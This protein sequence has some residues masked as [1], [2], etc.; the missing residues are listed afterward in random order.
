[1]TVPVTDND[2]RSSAYRLS[3]AIVA[4]L[5]ADGVDPDIAGNPDQTD[6]DVFAESIDFDAELYMSMS[7]D[8][9]TEEYDEI[10]KAA[11]DTK[12]LSDPNGVVDA[13]KTQMD[14][15]WHGEAAQTFSGQ[16]NRIQLCISKQHEF[17]LLAA[18]SVS[19]MYA[20]SVQFRASCQDLMEKT[21]ETCDAIAAEQPNPGLDWAAIGTSFAKAVIDG[22]KSADP[23]KVAGWAVDQLLGQATAA[24]EPRP[25]PGDKA[26]PVVS[27]YVSARDSLFVSYEDNLEQ[28]R[29]WIQSRWDELH[30]DIAAIPEPLPA[31]TDVDGPDF[32]YEN[33]AY[34]DHGH[35]AD[36]A[37][38]VERERQRYAAEKAKPGGVISQRLAGEG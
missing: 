11:L 14:A 25:V 21:A 16:L 15:W 35:P 3:G 2:L 38:E 28:I 33:F 19:M 22:I 13:L 36:Y 5:R 6:S 20:L 37:P 34:H 7:P 17:T 8:R 23:S 4:M 32:R 24:L 10:R 31:S 9:L 26:M 29:A 30:T 1:M 18:H 27:G 12:N